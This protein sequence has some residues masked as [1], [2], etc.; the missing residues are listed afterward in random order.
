MRVPIRPLISTAL[1][2]F[3]SLTSNADDKS[4]SPKSYKTKFYNAVSKEIDLLSVTV[5]NGHTR[6]E[7][8]SYH[9]VPKSSVDV[10]VYE[11]EL[12]HAVV[13]DT[14]EVVSKFKIEGEVDIYLIQW[15]VGEEL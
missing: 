7:G 13:T 2:L 10:E 14:D 11:G 15:D 9:V 4:D 12:V 6:Y 5:K 1:L 3:T 8:I